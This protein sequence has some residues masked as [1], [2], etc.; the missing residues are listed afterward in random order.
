MSCTGNNSLIKKKEGEKGGEKN[1]YIEA[2]TYLW[3]N[4]GIVGKRELL[5][6]DDAESF[7]AV[8]AG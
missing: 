6:G 8:R 1:S 7:I 2:P 3:A 5:S 4:W